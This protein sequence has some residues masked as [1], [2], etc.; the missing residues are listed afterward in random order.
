M[1]KGVSPSPARV[2]AVGRGTI[3][4]LLGDRSLRSG[5]E[6]GNQLHRLDLGHESAVVVGQ[7]R[8]YDVEHGSG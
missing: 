5:S 6:P 7:E 4:N 3:A 2:L 1:W 8:R